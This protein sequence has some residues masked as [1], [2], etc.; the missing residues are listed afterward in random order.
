MML[1]VHFKFID[2]DSERGRMKLSPIFR[3]MVYIRMDKYLVVNVLFYTYIT[4]SSG[5]RLSVYL[6][7]ASNYLGVW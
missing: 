5:C 4:D 7:H 1:L 3:R 2:V 6:P